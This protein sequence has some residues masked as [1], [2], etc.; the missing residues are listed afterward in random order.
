MDAIV[1]EADSYSAIVENDWLRKTK[2]IIDYNNNKMVIEWKGKVLEV[3]TECQEAPHHIV[4]IEA[5]G[6]EEEEE[7]VTEEDVIEE[8]EEEY[9]TDDDENLQ[10]QMYC[11][12]QFITQEETQEIEELLK[13]DTFVENECYYQYKEVEKGKFHTGNLDN[14]Q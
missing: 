10:E 4:S 3:I 12:T 9:E 14:E 6:V 1:T 2:A 5:F 13:D 11:N 8:S 7:E